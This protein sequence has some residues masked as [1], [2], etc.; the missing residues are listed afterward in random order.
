MRTHFAMS[1]TE[2]K[3]PQKGDKDFHLFSFVKN[4]LPKAN[5]SSYLQTNSAK[6]EPTE[7][8]TSSQSTSEPIS[9]S[10]LKELQQALEFLKQ[11]DCKPDSLG[12]MRRLTQMLKNYE[13][14][15][16]QS[17][18][19]LPD[20][21]VGV[22]VREILELAR[23]QKSRIEENELSSL[24]TSYA[25]SVSEFSVLCSDDEL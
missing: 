7:S 20:G 14:A 10:K 24:D 17:E 15:S 6:L 21:P 9:T 8:E 2:V 1:E 25:S 13:S 23:G 16:L 11:W 12:H 22:L 5:P 18:T 19:K 4:L 3:V